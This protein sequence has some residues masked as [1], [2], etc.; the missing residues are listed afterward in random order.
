MC[1]R[2]L[3][4]RSL[5]VDTVLKHTCVYASE[6]FRTRRFKIDNVYKKRHGEQYRSAK[7]YFIVKVTVELKSTF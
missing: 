1:R 2:F 4:T 6:L 5:L 3:G 7:S